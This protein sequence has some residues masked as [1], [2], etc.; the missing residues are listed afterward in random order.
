MGGMQDGSKRD[1][2]VPSTGLT[3]PGQPVPGVAPRAPAP[4]GARRRRLRT[5]G[6]IG[7]AFIAGAVVGPV[8]ALPTFQALAQD[9]L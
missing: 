4:T 8:I 9:G 6:A 1:A 5:L 3:L 2:R 7:A